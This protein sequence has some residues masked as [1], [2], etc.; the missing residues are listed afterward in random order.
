MYAGEQ[1]KGLTIS[2]TN[3]PPSITIHVGVSGAVA[4]LLRQVTSLV[5]HCANR[6]I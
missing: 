5:Y 4:S 2:G 6:T 3:W 1:G